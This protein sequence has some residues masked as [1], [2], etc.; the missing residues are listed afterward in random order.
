V[1]RQKDP[2]AMVFEPANWKNSLQKKKILGFSSGGEKKEK[3]TSESKL[4][5]HF[6]GKRTP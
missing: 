1:N 6:G 4:G 2:R 3:R 5:E